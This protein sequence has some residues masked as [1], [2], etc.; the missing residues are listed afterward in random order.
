MLFPVARFYPALVSRGKP[1]QHTLHVLWPS[2]L[3]V[4]FA[5]HDWKIHIG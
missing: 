1:D 5:P 4:D 3:F 2:G